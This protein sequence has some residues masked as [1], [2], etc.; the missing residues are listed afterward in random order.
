S[1][2]LLEKNGNPNQ[3]GGQF[4]LAAVIGFGLFLYEG[5][6][7]FANVVRA[8]GGWSLFAADDESRQL[9]KLLGSDQKATAS[10]PGDVQGRTAWFDLAASLLLSVGCLMTA[11]RGAAVSLI[12]GLGLLLFRGTKTQSTARLREVVALG[13]VLLFTAVGTAVFYE[14]VP[15]DRLVNRVFGTEKQGLTTLSGRVGIWKNAVGAI[16]SDAT[17]MTIG[18]GTGTADIVLGRMDAGA[19]YNDNGVLSRFSHN[20]YLEWLLYY[21]I[22]G[23]I[24]GAW[25]L[26]TVARAAHFWDARDGTVLRQAILLAIFCEG[27]TEVVFRMYSWIV[28]ASLLL[29]LLEGDLAF[30]GR[31]DAFR[32]VPDTIEIP[33]FAGDTS[34]AALNG[35]H[36]IGN[37]RVREPVS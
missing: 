14:I 29:A 20:T 11:S 18:A 35:G 17:M 21:G 31:P 36:T 10:D 19:R 33:R 7:K 25:L 37:R 22:L 15:W 5:R 24:P 6:K 26:Y 34:I 23:A 12:A 1:E 2:T 8:G 30:R 28:P 27:I 3:I 9:A 32:T 13:I 16:T 4:A